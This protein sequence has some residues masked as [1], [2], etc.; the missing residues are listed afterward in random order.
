[1]TSG[2]TSGV[3]PVPAVVETTM[4]TAGAFT[5][6]RLFTPGLRVCGCLVDSRMAA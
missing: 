5:G 4:L 2:R 6:P 3:A 1:M